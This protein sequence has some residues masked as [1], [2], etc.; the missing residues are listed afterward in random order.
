MT[1]ASF[2]SWDSARVRVG[3]LHAQ[4]VPGGVQHGALGGA[5]SECLI[6]QERI[7]NEIGPGG[8]C[9][10]IPWVSTTAWDVL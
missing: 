6:R 9:G 10:A 1:S 3:V 5:A 2:I 4:L 8:S 7:S